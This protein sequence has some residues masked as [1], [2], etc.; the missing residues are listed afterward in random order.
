MVLSMSALS[1]ASVY[2]TRKRGRKK[3]KNP[4]NGNSKGKNFLNR[5]SQGQ[6]ELFHPFDKFLLAKKAKEDGQF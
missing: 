4:L 5:D 2:I 6:S 3:V 1:P